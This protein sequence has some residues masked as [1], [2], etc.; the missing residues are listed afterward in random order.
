MKM[1]IPMLML[2]FLV[3]CYDDSCVMC[4][5]EIDMT[6]ANRGDPEEIEK[7]D[8]GNYHSWT[9]WYWSQGYSIT[10]TFSDDSCDCETSTYTFSP[11]Y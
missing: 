9:F 11:I 4:Q 10:F 6:V 2:L 3:G 8:S 5:D 7:F 1:I